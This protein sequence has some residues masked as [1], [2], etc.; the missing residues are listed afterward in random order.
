MDYPQTNEPGPVPQ[1]DIPGAGASAPNEPPAPP[2][3]AWYVDLTRAE[4]IRFRLVGARVSGPL[5]MRL[6]TL[7]LSLV[8]CGLLVALAIGE[9]LSAG[10]PGWPDPVLLAGAVLVLLPGLYG[11]FYVPA[12]LRALAARQYERSTGAGMSYCGRLEITP[13]SIAKIGATATARVTLDQRT[14]FVEDRDMMVFFAAGSPAVVLPGRCLSEPLAA[15]ARA[16]ADRL[17]ATNRRFLARLQAGGEAVAPPHEQPPQELWVATFTYQPEEYA[18]VL[19]GLMRQHFLRMAPLLA[20]TAAIGAL[21][22]GWDGTSLVPCVPYFLLIAAVLTLLNLV[23]PLSR[24]K[25]QVPLLS[26]HERTM[27]VRLDTVAVRMKL[28]RGNE[29]WVLWCDVEHVYDKEDFVEIVHNKHA[30]LHIPKRCIEDVA[31]F[32]AA[33]NRC[34]GN[35]PQ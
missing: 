6:P 35:T 29:N 21:L 13:D 32:E 26:V 11:W 18:T 28:P 19:K 16:A 25:R 4:V 2:E 8:C 9:W 7:L 33:V 24:V 34:R 5:K 14:L 20:L 17:P 3:P 31:A 23:L 1:T 10:R 12:R 27:Q 22:F 15:R 30:S